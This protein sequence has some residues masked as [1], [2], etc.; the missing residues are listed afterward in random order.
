MFYAFDLLHLDGRN[1]T[2]CPLEERRRELPNVLES[3]GILLSEPLQGS[4]DQVAAAV[5]PMSVRPTFRL[6]PAVNV[7]VAGL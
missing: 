4:A 7:L 1:L 6:G 3:S 2:G 5:P